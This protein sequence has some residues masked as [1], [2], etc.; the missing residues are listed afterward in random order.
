MCQTIFAFV[1]ENPSEATWPVAL[2]V[3]VH[4][5]NSRMWV[6]FPWQKHFRACR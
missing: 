6:S 1:G 5:R 2:C 3:F 4:C